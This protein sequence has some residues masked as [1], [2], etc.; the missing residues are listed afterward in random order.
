MGSNCNFIKPKFLSGLVFNTRVFRRISRSDAMV[1]RDSSVDVEV[2]FKIVSMN[3]LAPCY[4]KVSEIGR[5]GAPDRV[6][7]KRMS[8]IDIYRGMNT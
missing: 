3:V 2:E 8:R 6:F 1:M 7:L 4:R 5:N